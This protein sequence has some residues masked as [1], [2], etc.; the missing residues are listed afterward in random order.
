MTSPYER[1][2]AVRTD[3]G[4]GCRASQYKPNEGA[5]QRHLFL[6]SRDL[7][8]EKLISVRYVNTR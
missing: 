3:S 5:Q 1:A 6:P 4:G 7:R 2:N 8:E